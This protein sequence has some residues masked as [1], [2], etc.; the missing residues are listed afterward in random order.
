[1]TKICILGNSHVA[2]LKQGW[3]QIGE[4]WP[5]IN[6]QFFAQPGNDGLKTVRLDGHFL[7]SDHENAKKA[8]MTTH[9]AERLDL[10]SFDLFLI[11]GSQSQCLMLGD[12]FYSKQCIDATIDDLTRGTPAQHVLECLRQVTDAPIFVGHTP[13]R[14]ARTVRDRSVSPAY[15][16]GLG[17]LN[18]RHYAKHGAEMIGQPD[19]TIVNG[20][21]T[22]PKFSWGVPKLSG[23]L[24]QGGERSAASD[25]TH[26]DGAFGQLW[27][28][29]FLPKLRSAV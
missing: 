25:N 26:M 28:E 19:E 27:L 23:V 2:S 17:I 20:R 4:H 18:E 6:V 21:S 1:M 9:G 5:S 12:G 14:A 13:L 15:R 11:Y 16:A 3:D 10:R 8:F 24:T 7:T 29:A 22:A